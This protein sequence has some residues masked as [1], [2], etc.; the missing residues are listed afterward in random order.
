MLKK[1]FVLAIGVVIAQQV[2]SASEWRLIHDGEPWGFPK[3]YV[4]MQTFQVKGDVV[5]YWQRNYWSKNKKM[6]E[7]ANEVLPENE[8][9]RCEMD[10]KNGM[11]RQVSGVIKGTNGQ[12]L[13]QI[14]PDKDFRKINPNSRDA[15]FQKLICDL[16]KEV[17]A[18]QSPA[19]KEG[20][21]EKS[22]SQAKSTSSGSVA[23]KTEKKTTP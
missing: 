1:V 14:P 5:R 20:F 8:L 18:K 7:T 16:A 9:Y 11:I 12:T 15:K 21:A 2:A 6:S 10:C 17:T 19:S 23:P 22:T 3:S 4:D 13:K